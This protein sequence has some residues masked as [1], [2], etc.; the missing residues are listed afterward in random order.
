MGLWIATILEV[1][2]SAR[3]SD[4]ES[5][6]ETVPAPSDLGLTFDF[7]LAFHLGTWDSRSSVSSIEWTANLGTESVPISPK[8]RGHT[9]CL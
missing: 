3:A 2:D 7:G 1:W 8:L 9:L 5:W 6:D 4:L